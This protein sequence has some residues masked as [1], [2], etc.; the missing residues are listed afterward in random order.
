VNLDLEKPD[1]VPTYP[2][3]ALIGFLGR[4]TRVF[5]YSL[6]LSVGVLVDALWG[7]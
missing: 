1:S 7:D 4:P 6:P 2:V 3:V 5:T